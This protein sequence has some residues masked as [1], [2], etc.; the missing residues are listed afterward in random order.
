LLAASTVVALAVSPLPVLS[1]GRA[2][3]LLLGLVVYYALVFFPPD[4][5]WTSGALTLAGVVVALAGLVGTDWSIAPALTRGWPAGL[6]D[7]L[8]Q[9]GRGL[10]G[11]Q[12]GAAF[13]LG[14][15]R[16]VGGLLA[17]LLPVAVLRSWSD[18]RRAAAR[19]GGFGAGAGTTAW[20]AA[21]IAVMAAVLLLSQSVSATGGVLCALWLCAVLADRARRRWW[22]AG[23]LLALVAGGVVAAL[24]LAGRA[25][26]RDTAAL[27]SRP[28]PG[29]AHA[30]FGVAARLEIWWR[31]LE[32]VR[33]APYTGA[34]LALFPRIMDRFYPGYILGPERHAHNVL[35][36]TAV[37]L[38]LPGLVALIWLLLAF[39]LH[40]RTT[41]RTSADPAV[42]AAGLGLGAGL[43][44]FL[45]FGTIDAIPLGSRPGLALWVVLGAGVALRAGA[46]DGE[47]ARERAGPPPGARRL[48]VVMGGLLAV[49]LAA[50]LAW[51]GQDLN[52]GR[53]LAYRALLADGGADTAA[54]TAAG[55]LLEGAAGRDAGGS[56]T[57]YLLGIVAA[58][59]GEAERSLAALRR[60]VL[61]DAAAPLWRY[62]P[63]E[64]LGAPQGRA[65]WPALQRVYAQWTTRYP[66]RAEWYAASAIALC[67][68][69]GDRQGARERVA[70]GA[71]AGAAPGALLTA[72]ARRLDAGGAC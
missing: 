41:L 43:L 3:G 60:G 63:A 21:G 44:A 34:G 55:E 33:D 45:L 18:G 52:A 42:R 15:P 11:R 59:N 29:V 22:L 71:A 30:T 13:E 40:L 32:M 20:T 12:I 2:G 54:L 19:P 66:A 69:E 6:Y 39:A 14:N 8:A 48:A 68:G 57:W 10:P 5:R 4:A 53:L 47:H 26:L 27:P 67:A 58:H 61:A 25:G 62:A 38:G 24:L 56:A 16:D 36:Q 7:A 72:Y 35:L 70:Q 23:G 50:P 46:G 51:D 17:L 37:D 64:A 65:G 28:E 49:S 9:L 31:G 1:A